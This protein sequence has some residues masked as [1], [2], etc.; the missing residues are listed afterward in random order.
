MADELTGVCPECGGE[1]PL[2]M[3]GAVKKH[4]RTEADSVMCPGSG[5]MPKE[6]GR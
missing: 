6:D 4:R 5:W 2:A 3:N 1:I